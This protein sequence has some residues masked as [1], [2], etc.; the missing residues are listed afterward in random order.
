M[1]EKDLLFS[2]HINIEKEEKKS[3][4]QK[5]RTKRRK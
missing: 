1:D 4:G 5:R 3:Q 2:I